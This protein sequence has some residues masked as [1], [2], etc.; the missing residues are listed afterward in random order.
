M[1]AADSRYTIHPRDCGKEVRLD[2][3]LPSK[4]RENQTRTVPEPKDMVVYDPDHPLYEYRH[5]CFV[6]RKVSDALHGSADVDTTETEE[7]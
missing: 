4:E 6:L 1:A 3:Q 2:N 5:V 7:Y